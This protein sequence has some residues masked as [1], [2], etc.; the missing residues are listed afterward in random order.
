[1]DPANSY[2]VETLRISSQRGET[3][4]LIDLVV[5]LS[6]SFLKI[7]PVGRADRNENRKA[8]KESARAS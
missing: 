3:F 8:T 2:Y 4:L 7:N 6:R 1:M 5:R